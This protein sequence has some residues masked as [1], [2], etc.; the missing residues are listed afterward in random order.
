MFFLLSFIH[1]N[2]GVRDGFGNWVRGGF[3]DK[4]LV[5]T[6]WKRYFPRWRCDSRLTTG[7]WEHIMHIPK[8]PDVTS[9]RVW[10]SCAHSHPKLL[11]SSDM[12]PPAV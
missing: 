3:S 2:I 5:L 4:T 11:D 8:L 1:F 10:M 7:L 9:K 6:K 12:P